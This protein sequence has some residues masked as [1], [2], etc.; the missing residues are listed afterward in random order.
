MTSKVLFLHGGPGLTAAL[1]RRRW[2]HLPVH[3]WDQPQFSP[4]TPQAYEKLVEAALDQLAS[5]YKPDRTPVPLLASSFGAHLAL[6][7]MERAPEQIGAVSI[8]GGIVDVRAALV[9]LGRRM[10]EFKRDVTLAEA[11]ESA[12]REVE[13][14]WALIEHLFGLPG[15]LECYWSPVAQA[16]CEEMLDLAAAGVLLHGPTFQSVLREVFLRPLPNGPR[17]WHAPLTVWLGR[18]DPYCRESDERNWEQLL[19]DAQ[20]RWVDA[21]HFPHLELAPSLW[22]PTNY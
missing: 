16:Q 22:M 7:L 2:G 21:G 12:A 15:L 11:S 9:Q 4:E 14:I 6:T 10:A 19:P 18:H 8:V 20:V 13:P 3:W 1:E 17:D 5:L